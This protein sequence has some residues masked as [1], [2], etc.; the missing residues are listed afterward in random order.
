M[1][2]LEADAVLHGEAQPSPHSGMSLAPPRTVRT[3]WG[4]G[5]R[6][7]QGTNAP[8]RHLR[9][10]GAA[11]RQGLPPAPRSPCWFCQGPWSLSFN[12]PRRISLL[13]ALT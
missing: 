5:R 6:G 12:S 13:L 10:A 3:Q 2:A 1:A 11:Q 7:A 9:T 8:S 4:G